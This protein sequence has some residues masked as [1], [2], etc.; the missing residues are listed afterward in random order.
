VETKIM[1]ASASRQSGENTSKAQHGFSLIE[2]LIVVAI[3]L[4]IAAIAIPNLL[5]SKKAA[6]QSSAVSV[7]RTVTTASVS[8]WV[9]YSNGYPPSLAA[10]GGPGGVAA[11]CN[12]AILMDE[13]VT[14]APYQKS[15]YQFAYTGTQGNIANPPGGCTPGFQGYLA[16]AAPTSLGVTGNSSYC[17]DEAGILHQNTTGSVP[18]TEAVCEALPALQ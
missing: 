13:T 18:A 5:Q 6:N 10:M 9:T 12:L 1:R 14:V 7:L 15:G 11:T 16:T 8:Y 17:I 3:I 4:I 2:L